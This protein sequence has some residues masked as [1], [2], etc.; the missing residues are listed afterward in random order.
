MIAVKTKIKIKTI[1]RTEMSTTMVMSRNM[2]QMMTIEVRIM[3]PTGHSRST[4]DES[5]LM[6]C[7][8]RWMTK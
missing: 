3:E 4:K 5:T 2:A 8:G 1:T 7:L 6:A